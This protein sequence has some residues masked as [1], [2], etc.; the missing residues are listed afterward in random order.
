MP[1]RV[2]ANAEM[3]LRR[4]QLKVLGK[5]LQSG[6]CF[7]A[8]SLLFFFHYVTCK[9]IDFIRIREKIVKSK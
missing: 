2:S 1:F 9:V 8:H 7:S 6:V 4:R 3:S 5:G